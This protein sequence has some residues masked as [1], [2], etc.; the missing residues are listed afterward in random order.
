M[1]EKGIFP[2]S[3]TAVPDNR[4]PAQIEG[5]EDGTSREIRS[6]ESKKEDDTPVIGKRDIKG[7]KWAMAV[8]AILAST[9]LFALDTT[10]VADIQSHII[11]SVGE[12]EKFSW[13]GSAFVLPAATL[14]LPWAKAY[15]LFNIKWLYLA[16][17]TVFEIGSAISGAAPTMDALIV[18]R[19]IAG[20]GGCGMYL[21]SLS[22]LSVATTPKERPMY[23]SLVTPV[24]GLGTVL[25]PIVGGAF[26]DSAVGWRW[27]FYVNLLIFVVLAPSI[28]FILP[29]LN[30]SPNLNF[31]QKLVKFDWLS[32]VLFVGWGIAFIMAL[33]FGGT[34]YAWESASEIILWVFT[35]VLAIAFVLSHIFHPFIDAENR[36][37]PAHML[38]NRKLGVLQLATFAAPGAVYVPIYY[39]PLYF[40]F[41]RG[42]SAVDAAVR[43]LPFVFMVV[44]MS[45]IN[46]ALTSKLGYIFPWFLAGGLLSVAGGALMFTVSHETSNSAIYGYS[47]VLGLG[48]G[49]LLMSAFGCVAAVIEEE[50]VFNAVGVLSIAQGLGIVFF[51]STSGIIFQNL[52]INYIKPLL[53]PGF[54]G[55]TSG[56]LAGSSSPEYQ[57]FSEEVRDAISQAIV[58]AM[59]RV[60]TLSIAAGSLTVLSSFLLGGSKV[61]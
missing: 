36:Y 57:T 43:L 14:Q 18:G 41:A 30:F 7:F 9:F 54:T 51:V 4:P 29:S 8:F 15:S 60:Y 59:S 2:E 19:A 3:G 6:D 22:F 16:D 21:G 52:R 38:R 34:V 33:Q 12:F 55:H 31:K 35:G 27:G 47:V 58:T 50:D 44:A 25:G 1:S 39:L 5:E 11:N 46:G 24:W 40:Q 10:V 26:A 42:D 20:V 17:V 32:L 37:Y 13:L 53:P 28:L 48:G 23:L 56:I 61:E 49:C 45:I